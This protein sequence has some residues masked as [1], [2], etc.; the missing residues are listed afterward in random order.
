MQK[1]WKSQP[2]AIWDTACA[3]QCEKVNQKPSGTQHVLDSV[4]G[5]VRH[6]LVGVTKTQGNFYYNREFFNWSLAVGHGTAMKLCCWSI[7]QPTLGRHSGTCSM[8]WLI[9]SCK[10]G[11]GGEPRWVTGGTGEFCKTKKHLLDDVRPGGG[12]LLNDRWNW[13]VL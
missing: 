4:G 1:S 11:Q 12:I 8:H 9:R 5:S 6:L 2:K 13:G 10:S 7:P 3:R